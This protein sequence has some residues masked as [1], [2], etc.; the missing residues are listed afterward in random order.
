MNAKNPENPGLSRTQAVPFGCGL[1][2]ASWRRAKKGAFDLEGCA[3]ASARVETPPQ[4]PRR[5]RLTGVGVDVLFMD[6]NVVAPVD[7]LRAGPSVWESPSPSR[8]FGQISFVSA[9]NCIGS[10]LS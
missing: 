6:R 2:L 9:Q 5:G 1:E 10:R 4:V 3:R 7:A 8:V